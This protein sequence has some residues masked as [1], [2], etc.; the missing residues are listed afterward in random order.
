MRVLLVDGTEQDARFVRDMLVGLEGQSFEVVWAADRAEALARVGTA[1]APGRKA[2]DVLLLN[3]AALDAPAVESLRTLVAAAPRTPVVLLTERE[4][5]CGGLRAFELGAQECLPRAYANPRMLARTLR[6]ACERTRANE[7]LAESEARFRRMAENARDMIYR[8]R[9]KPDL[10]IEYVSPAGT[11]ITG[12]TPEDVAGDAGAF[13]R[14]LLHP[15]DLP[16]FEA[17]LQSQ[18]REEPPPLRLMHKDGHVVWT[19]HRIVPVRDADGHLVAI[20][21]VARD[22]SAEHAM[23]ETDHRSEEQ[24]ILIQKLEAVG[25]LAGG[26]AHDFNNI[27]TSVIGYSELLLHRLPLE[28]PIRKTVAEIH[29]AGQRATGLTQQLLAFSRRQMLQPKVLDLNAE[30]REIEELFRRTLGEDIEIRLFLAGDLGR[31]KVDP[32]RLHQVLLNLVVNARDAMPR[33]GRLTIETANVHHDEDYARRHVGVRVG[34]YVQLTISDSGVGMDHETL[35]H[36]FEPFFTTKEKGKGTGLGLSTAYGI[37]KQSGGNIWAYSEPGR[38]TTFEV[39]FP[40]V[41]EAGEPAPASLPTSPARGGTETILLVEDEQGVR[42]LAREVLADLGY[43]V[44]SGGDGEQALA[45]AAAHAEPIH[46]LLTDV[47][48]PRMSGRVLAERLEPLRPGLRILYMSGYTEDAIIQ[49]GLLVS[50]IAFLEKPFNPTRL[51][52]KVRQVLDAPPP[53]AP[54]VSV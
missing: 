15:E 5:L 54:T 45:L 11:A 20:E 6:Y 19:Q 13:I 12:W 4:D 40:L 31:V 22:I 42:D 41:T 38:G 53:A 52:L 8:L 36:M 25:R 33:G 18:V 26:I 2:W 16:R 47:V 48:M 24:L 17:A 7:A 37:V 50:G 39:Y 43:R 3:V 34:P 35:S 23:Q 28:D 21:G 10:A 14:R 9:L 32:D 29:K 44:L 51:G 46:L 49:H 27:M 30:L 1:G